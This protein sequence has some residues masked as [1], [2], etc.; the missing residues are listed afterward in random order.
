MKERHF[1]LVD[2]LRAPVEKRQTSAALGTD[3][4]IAEVIAGAGPHYCLTSPV[5]AG[6]LVTPVGEARRAR[7][8]YTLIHIQGSI[9]AGSRLIVSAIPDELGTGL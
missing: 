1:A 9:D 7:L 6:A 3:S 2:G 4:P 8:V 5:W